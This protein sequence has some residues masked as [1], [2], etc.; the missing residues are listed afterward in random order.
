MSM[1]K[2]RFAYLTEEMLKQS[3]EEALSMVGGIRDWGP[4]IS[5]LS[6]IEERV[7]LEEHKLRATKHVLR[8]Y[9]G[10]MSSACVPFI[11]DEMRKRSIEEGRSKDFD[12]EFYLDL[13]Q[14]LH[15]IPNGGISNQKAFTS[16]IRALAEIKHPTIVKLHGFCSKLQFSFLVYEFLQGGSLDNVLKNEEQATKFGWNK[17]VNMVKDVAN[18]LFHMHHGCSIPIVHRDI[19]SKNVLLSSEHEQAHIMNLEHQSFWT[20]HGGLNLLKLLGSASACLNCCT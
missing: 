6:E 12:G 5:V 20:I 4:D 13:V 10:N 7:G 17:R 14:K 11:L 3:L 19:S 9:R 1:I 16:E 18:A 15:S 2:K 8:E